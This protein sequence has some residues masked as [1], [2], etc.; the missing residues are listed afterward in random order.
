MLIRILYSAFLSSPSMLENC[1]LCLWTL[2]LLF[3][4]RCVEHISM[5]NLYP[6]WSVRQMPVGFQVPKHTYRQ[7]YCIG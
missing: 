4:S 2:C 5:R 1:W 6:T 7:A 3:G